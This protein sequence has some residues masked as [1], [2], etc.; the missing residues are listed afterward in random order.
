MSVKI[1]NFLKTM[2]IAYAVTGI[3]LV[4]LS[5]ALYKVGL[6]EWQVS[7]GIIVT[8]A[9]SAFIGAYIIAKS[10]RSRRLFW[11]IGFGIIYFA[12]LMLVSLALSGGVAIDKAAVI[13]SAVICICA[14][15]I[16]AFATPVP[17]D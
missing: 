14:G 11:G 1:L 16:G 2:V 10:E 15:A 6:S 9:V 7:A 3:M 8:Y 17:K 5:F 13:R 4:I 12:I